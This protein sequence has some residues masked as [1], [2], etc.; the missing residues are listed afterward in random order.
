MY[1]DIHLEHMNWE[2]CLNH[3]VLL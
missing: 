2:D 3:F 1:N